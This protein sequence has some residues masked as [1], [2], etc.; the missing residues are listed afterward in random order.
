[1][2]IRHPHHRQTAAALLSAFML[3][4]AACRP[5]DNLPAKSSKEY[6]EVVRAFYIGLAALQVGD[7][8]RADSK[9]AQMTQLVPA[10]P[11]GWANW[12]LLAL[13][14]RNFD[15]AAERLERARSLAPENDQI[16]YLLGLLES[17]RGRSTEA[18]T[19]LRKAIEIN[20]KNLVATYKLAEEVERQGD[21]NS[22]AE[23]QRLIQKMLEIQ[24]DNLA[25]LLELGRIAAKRGDA[26]TL[27]GVVSKI[28]QRGSAW[29]AEVQQQLTAVQTAATGP[30]VRQAATRITFLRN[31]LVRV[32]EYRNDL[33][34][35]KPPPGEE[36][37]PFTHFL[38]ME[39]PT[40]SPATADTAIS[41][42][43]DPVPNAPAGKWSWI[44]AISLN[45]E[46]APAVVL[47]NEIEVRIGAASYPFPG[48][49]PAVPP[50]PE[51]VVGLDFDYDFKTDLVLVGAG[52]V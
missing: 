2:R 5:A 44:G 43:S 6:N 24:P 34:N 38:K 31:V 20:P 12:G 18:V 28:S 29:P 48:G 36:A 25:V 4:A 47:A 7:D 49:A 45:G 35:I 17:S 50:G 32:L 37:Q 13:R 19:A 27:R 15:P 30:D 16:F 39:T 22:E 21:E 3:L 41:F 10:E 51:A 1:M 52:G 11:A 40:F 14:Q 26:D 9:L 23:Y 46:G 8:V 33:S 42:S